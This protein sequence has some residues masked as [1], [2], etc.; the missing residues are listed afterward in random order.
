MISPRRLLVLVAAGLLVGCS[1]RVRPVAPPPPSSLPVQAATL[2]DLGLPAV[3][4]TVDPINATISRAEAEVVAGESELAQGRRLAARQRFDVAVDTLLNVPGGARADARLRAEYERLLDRIS[5]HESLDLRTGD[6]FAE[7]RS[8]P[9][10]I[11]DLL[12]VGSA[13]R[14]LVPARTTAEI[15]AAD[16]AVTPHDIPITVN[17]KVLSY[18]ELFQTELRAFVEDGLARG[19][20]Y[21]PMI[22]EVFQAKGLPLDLA[23]VPLIES[24]FKST[25]LSRAKAKGMWQFMTPTARDVGLHENWFLDERADPEKA[26]RGAAVYLRDLR[27]MFDGDWS[28]ALAAYNAGQGRVQRAMKA[29]KKTDYWEITRTSRYLPR[30]TREYVPMIYAAMLIAANPMAYGFEIETVEP[31]AYDAVTVPDALR[32]GT[33]AEWL[34]VPVEEIQSLNPELRRGM[35]P[36]GNHVLKVPVGMGSTVEGRLA[37]ASPDVFASAT[38]R[39]H[40]VKKGETLAA[41][42]RRYKTTAS[43]LAAANDLRATSR[44]R[45]GTSLMVPASPAPALVSAPRPAAPKATAAKPTALASGS[46]AGATTTYRVRSG[47]NLS[48]IARQ[49]GMSVESLKTMNRLSSDA[50]SV[51]DRLTVRR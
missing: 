16:L 49:F 23:Y 19:S 36:I 48:R 15:V 34:N 51:G 35:T 28:L 5:A 38:F 1:A 43:K 6:G 12:A 17:D 44:V 40:T 26:T 37:S 13:D 32:L 33:V 3:T 25:A 29:A 27:A 47:D 42:A 46:A 22:Q 30:E 7:A 45:G 2:R 18:V 8:E 20:R 50:L 39:F 14:P 11:D 31:L 41:I 4:L 21:L 9:A 10:A 24:A